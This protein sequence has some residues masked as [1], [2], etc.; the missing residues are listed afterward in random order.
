MKILPG[1]SIRG[2]NKVNNVPGYDSNQQ[3]MFNSATSSFG[4]NGMPPQSGGV[5]LTS[6]GAQIIDPGDMGASV[7]TINMDMVQEVKV[8][9]SNFGADTAK[10]PVVINAVGKSGSEQYHGSL[11]TYVRDGSMNSLDAYLKS[12]DQKKPADR[13]ISGGNIGGP[14]NIPGTNLKK[15]MFFFAGYE[16]YNQTIPF[17]NPISAQVPTLGQR[18]GDFSWDSVSSL[19]AG[20]MPQGWH[21]YTDWTDPSGVTH[22]QVLD[23][24]GNGPSYCQTPTHYYDAINQTVT[25]LPTSH[26]DIS[27]YMD[28]GALAYLKLFPLPNV[29]ATKENG[30]SNYVYEPVTNDNS[31]QGRGRLDYNF[32]EKNKL[33]GSYNIQKEASPSLQA[34]YWAPGSAIQ[35]PGNVTQQMKS[36][37]ISLNYLRI[38]SPTL[39][40][41]AKASLVLFN[42]PFTLTNPDSVSRSGLGYPYKGIF[43]NQNDQVPGIVNWYP[44]GFPMVYM[45]GGFDNGSL[46]S[47]KT[48]YNLSDDIIKLVGT[49][50]LKAGFYYEKTANGQFQFA[51]TNGSYQFADTWRYEWSGAGGNANGWQGCNGTN[52]V[53]FNNT[54][55]LLMGLATSYTQ[56]AKALSANMY[57]KNISFYGSDSWKVSKRL[58]LDLGL[59]VE[60]VGPWTDSRGIGFAVFDQSLYNKQVV[61]DN[62]NGWYTTKS[63]VQYP[64]MVWH[65]SDSS[66]P[67]SGAP[68]HAPFLSPRLG[69]AWDVFGTGKTVVR[70]GFG[71]YRWHDSYNPYAGA[72]N[73]GLGQQSVNVSGAMS[74]ASIDAMSAGYASG[75]LG[76]DGNAYFVDRNDTQ[77]PLTKNWNL[78]VSRQMPWSSVVEVGY[79]GNESTHLIP[80]GQLTS[81][82][83]IPLGALYQRDLPSAAVDSNVKGLISNL[84]TNE[85]DQYRPYSWYTETLQTTTHNGW[86]NYHALQASWNRQKGW[87]T[88][89]LNYTFSKALGLFTDA[90]PLNFHDDYGPLGIDRTHAFNAAYSFDLGHRIQGNPLLRGIL[91]NW[92]LS[93]VTGYQSGFSVQSANDSNS[94]GFSFGGATVLNTYN[95]DPAAPITSP[96]ASVYYVQTNSANLLGT[97]DVTLQPYFTCDPT[98]PTSGVKNSYMN[99]NC[100]Q[101]PNFLQ[102][103]PVYKGYFHSPGYFN[104][105][106]TIAKAFNLVRRSNCSSV[107]LLSI[108]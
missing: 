73:P 47:R 16:Y 66:I 58:T 101:V 53:C 71:M 89:G 52:P 2:A 36:D 93:G 39:T 19:C 100:Y 5:S 24:Q 92:M 83:I 34:I 54:A 64:G 17:S 7:A 82:N 96:N 63:T 106:L 18:K 90:N 12:N 80:P 75:Q 40:N 69:M 42:G 43:Q 1:F 99:T 55:D 15:K 79:V 13:Y 3:S 77:Q 104:S 25:K 44:G 102:N 59:R 61:Q 41:E 4:A 95:Y 48:S 105:D 33:Y 21:P 9:T 74:F 91:N 32:N 14:V 27:Q 67:L 98:K 84:T 87:A 78:T 26:G 60:Y 49:H 11:Y 8:Q 94:T 20:Q 30:W 10:G 37:S 29:T 56:E 81:R 38:F 62:S 107:L 86:A 51:Q 85:M 76:P 88:F 108:S 35:Y 70:G 68:N 6:D 23:N 65:A 103:G 31:W 97:P 50:T 57:F 72:L 28:P 22:T 45:Q 46:E